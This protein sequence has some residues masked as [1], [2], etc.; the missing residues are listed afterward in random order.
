MFKPTIELNCSVVNMYMNRLIN[1]G[2]VNIWFKKTT[3][4]VCK[5]DRWINRGLDVYADL[6]YY[7]LKCK[8]ISM[9]PWV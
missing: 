8:K 4:Y 3:T 6:Q 2:L 7:K 1:E 9:K 5:T